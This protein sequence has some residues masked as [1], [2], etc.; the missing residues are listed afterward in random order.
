MAKIVV[1][2][3]TRYPKFVGRGVEDVEK[4]WYLCEVVWRAFQTPDATKII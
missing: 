4:H 1:D 2:S 3:L